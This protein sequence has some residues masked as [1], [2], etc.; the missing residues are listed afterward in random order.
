MPCGSASPA[1]QEG[2]LNLFDRI[3]AGR[4]IKDFGPLEEWSLGLGRIRKSLLG[5]VP[6]E[7]KTAAFR[8]TIRATRL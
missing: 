8:L 2:P 4:V 7:A 1:R 5:S 6:N 3:F